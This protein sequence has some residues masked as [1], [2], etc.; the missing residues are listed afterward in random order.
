MR[1]VHPFMCYRVILSGCV[2]QGGYSIIRSM[3]EEEWLSDEDLKAAMDVERQVYGKELNAAGT[4]GTARRLF[5][6]NSAAAANSI[7]RLAKHGSNEKI[8]FRAAQYVLERAL[9]P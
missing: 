1:Q 2:L 6:E 9:G 7:I 8:R 3:S 5:A 4:V